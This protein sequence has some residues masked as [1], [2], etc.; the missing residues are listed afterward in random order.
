VFVREQGIP[1]DIEVDDY[2]GIC[3]H[4]VAY[5]DHRP[6]GTARLILV[7]RFTAKIG[8]VAVLA[9]ARHRGIATQLMRLLEDYARREGVT[10]AVLDAQ[11]QVLE[12]Y[13]RLGYV[14]EGEPFLDAGIVH[15]RMS[16]AL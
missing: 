3:W 4:A 6:V 7:D 1:A 5:L 11:T 12:L 8:R 2:D 16:K 10:R 13:E 14:V 9:E 15:K